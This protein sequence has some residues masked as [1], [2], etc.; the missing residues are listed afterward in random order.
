MN[1]D[2]RDE[3]L[4]DKGQHNVTSFIEKRRR[5]KSSIYLLPNLITATSLFF[6]LLAIKYS[7][8]GRMSGEMQNFV[9]AAYAIL[10]A[11]IC[12]GLDGSVARLTHTQSSFGVQLDSLC[13]LVSFGVAPAVVIY[14]YGLNEFFRLGFCVAFIFAACG[15]LRLARFNV[16]SSMGR[17]NGNFTGIP[18]PMAAAPLAVFIMAQQELASWTIVDHS[19]WEVTLAQALTSADVRNTTLLVITFL[20]ALGMISTFEY[21]SHKA[22]RLPRKRPFRVFAAVLIIFAL[23]LNIQFVVSLA[24]LLIIY[25]SHGPILWLFTRK[26]R[27]EEEDELFEAGN[28]SEES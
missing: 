15:A 18:I 20:L 13:D 27:A 26:D 17:A 24:L 9:F 6:G 12:D 7:I 28:N 2:L 1:S 21:I 3:N 10:A 14:N 16:Q 5:V 25:C 23:F 22:I 19:Q 8:D 4:N 11:G